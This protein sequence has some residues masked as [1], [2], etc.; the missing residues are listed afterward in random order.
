MADKRTADINSGA[1]AQP[2]T[3]PIHE[4]ER[5]S[6]RRVHVL[7]EFGKDAIQDIALQTLLDHA[8]L[9]IS[10]AIEVEHVKILEY[11][12]G[13]SDLLVVAGKGWNEGV[14]GHV[15]LAID[16]ATPAGR[17]LQTAQPVTVEDF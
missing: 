1:D 5:P 6:D 11:R 13:T 14:V 15:R 17:A 3:T 8:V 4:P 9:R 2:E 16:L 10:Q 7:A 12:P